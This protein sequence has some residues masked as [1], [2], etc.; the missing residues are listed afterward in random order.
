MLFKLVLKSLSKGKARFLCAMLGVASAVGAVAF[1]FSLTATNDAQAPHTARYLTAPWQAWKIDGLE[2]RGRGRSS[3]KS[4]EEKRVAITKEKGDKVF[5]LV[6]MTIDYRPD[7]RVLQGPPMIAVI[8][9]TPKENPYKNAMLE[10]RFPDNNASE[11]EVV[12]TRGTMKRFGRGKIPQIGESVKFVGQKGTLTARITGYLSLEKLPMGFPGAFVNDKAFATLEKEKHG[13][14]HL[15]K[16]PPKKEIKGLQTPDAI[17]VQFTSD[18]S[19]N[20]D[21]A[22]PLML[23]AAVLTA[24]CLLVNSLILSLEAKRKEIATLRLVGLTKWGVV[25]IVFIES[26]LASSAGM[27]TG[28]SVAMLSLYLYVKSDPATFPM[29]VVFAKGEIIASIIS[30]IVISILSVLIILKKVLTLQVLDVADVPMSNRKRSVG[31]AVTFAF[32]V[33]AFVAVEVWGASLMKAFIPSPELPDAIVSL[34]PGGAS[35]FDIEKLKNLPGVKKIAELQPLQL[36]FAEEGKREEKTVQGKM[37]ARSN[38]LLLASDWLPE[39]KFTQSDYASAKAKIMSSDSCII[40]DM[41]ARARKL[42]VGDKIKLDSRGAVIELEVAGVVDL[43]WHMVT[44]R[45]LVRGLNRMPSFTDGPLFVS[46]DTI[47]AAD[48]RPAQMVRMTHV[49]LDYEDK[50]LKENGVFP[51]GRK[52]EKS[53]VEALGNPPDFTTRL[54]SRDEIADGTLSHGANLIGAMAR[55]PFIFLAVLSIGF[56][57]LLVAATDASKREYMTLR[58]VGATHAQIMYRLLK[59]ALRAAGWGICFGV[60]G[61]ALAG[62]LFT[63]MTRSAMSHWGL[64]PSFV[65]PYPVIVQGVMGAVLFM[66]LVSIPTSWILVKRVKV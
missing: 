58:A 66:L 48:F 10:G 50:F 38:A 1:M 39:F 64:P 61:G 54:H 25:K 59:V 4:G 57:A 30:A 45:G 9:K 32:G 56:V 36:Y 5:D 52:V 44:S 17:A 26:F 14:L 18:A 24:L 43:N 31:M 22:K 34:L 60:P 13:K 8:S 42:K 6:G 49:W 37:K 63:G 2:M 11:F 51:S 41:M 33:G 15:W 65:V 53:I 46:F 12:L 27:V 16:T 3:E 55:I 19:R 28:I 20:M 47:A 62:W 40:T 35:S 23:W 7:G 29:G 21:R